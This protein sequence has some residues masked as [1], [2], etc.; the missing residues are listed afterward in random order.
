[1]SEL[2]TLAPELERPQI[3]G[4]RIIGKVDPL[5][6]AAAVKVDAGADIRMNGPEDFPSYAAEVSP[7]FDDY[8]VNFPNDGNVCV[9]ASH[10]VFL[11]NQIDPFRGRMQAR[12]LSRPH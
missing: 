5:V 2:I 10:T 1:M 4:L 12:D 11:E 6:L 9:W 7:F 8:L 3:E